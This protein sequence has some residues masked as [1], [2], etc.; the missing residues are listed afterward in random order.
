MSVLFLP[1]PLCPV[2]PGK[3]TP[4]KPTPQKPG[5]DAVPIRR[6]PA[7]AV[8]GPAT[9]GPVNPRS[10]NG[11]LNS[12]PHSYQLHGKR[13][14]ATCDWELPSWTRVTDGLS[15]QPQPGGPSP[16]AAALAHCNPPSP[17]ILAPSPLHGPTLLPGWTPIPLHDAC[18]SL[19]TVR[20]CSANTS[21]RQ[22]IARSPRSQSERRWLVLR[23]ADPATA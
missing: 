6:Q 21:T 17:R 1:S 20:I 18:H 8:P 14:T 22:P 11:I 12:V 5:C 19:P 15:G 10:L 3:A 7:A 16:G 23:P 9:R 2:Q 13:L 4:Q